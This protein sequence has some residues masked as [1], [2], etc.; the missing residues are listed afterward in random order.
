MTRLGLMIAMLPCVALGLVPAGAHA[1][2]V[3]DADIAIV[4]VTPSVRFAKVGDVVTFTVVATNNGPAPA[5]VD[6]YVGNQLTSLAPVLYTCDRGISPDTPACE[7]GALDAGQSVTTILSAEVTATG[8]KFATI[9]ACVEPWNVDSDPG[10]DCAT[11]SIRIV[12]RRKP[13]D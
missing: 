11:A 8:A 1:E 9:T 7:Y 6:T 2:E 4:S 3:P 10:N 13:S 5:E 12:G